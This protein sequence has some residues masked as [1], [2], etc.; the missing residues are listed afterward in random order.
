MMCPCG[1]LLDIICKRIASTVA[2]LSLI[3]SAIFACLHGYVPHRP[4]AWAHAGIS[5]WATSHRR[6]L[7][8]LWLVIAETRFDGDND[9]LYSD[10]ARAQSARPRRANP[11][12]CN[13]TS[14]PL[15]WQLQNAK[16]IPLPLP[17]LIA[18]VRTR[19]RNRLA[20]QHGD[21]LICVCHIITCSL[22]LLTY[23]VSALWRRCWRNV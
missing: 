2:K 3:E 17:T 12:L 22:Y 9:M 15:F 13:L 1:I 4:R 7:A 16:G 23:C 5:Q 14:T 8:R 21:M 6:L 10:I 20:V 11:G 18:A 19:A